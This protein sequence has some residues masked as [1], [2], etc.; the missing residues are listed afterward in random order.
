M[1]DF[2]SNMLAVS[3]ILGVLLLA[4][5]KITNK[6]LPDFIREIRKVFKEQDE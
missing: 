5:L 3:I 6:T 4:Y 2:W 1:G